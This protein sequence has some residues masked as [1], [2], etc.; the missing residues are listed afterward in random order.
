MTT[1]ESEGPGQASAEVVEEKLAL[2]LGNM[3][4]AE[5][6]L[7]VFCREDK[8]HDHEAYRRLRAAMTLVSEAYDAILV[9]VRR[10]G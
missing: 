4:E 9:E 8:P 6:R 7:R 3:Q 10:A 1:T 2:A 5:R